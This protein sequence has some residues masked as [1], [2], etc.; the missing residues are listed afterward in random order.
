MHSRAPRR[1]NLATATGVIAVMG[2]CSLV[3]VAATP[4]AAATASPPT[5]TVPGAAASTT[6]QRVTLASGLTAP[7]PAPGSGT[8]APIGIT[9]TRFIGTP[10]ATEPRPQTNGSS[11]VVFAAT[12]TGT[13]GGGPI[14]PSLAEIGLTSSYSLELPPY[15]VYQATTP[16]TASGAL[17]SSCACYRCGDFFSAEADP[18]NLNAVWVTGMYAAGPAWGT[19][20]AQV[21]A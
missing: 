12:G 7:S 13:S 4:T 21:A 5:V 19:Q 1:W 15:Y 2:S 6:P 17:D 8:Q 11:V 3:G 9:S 16:Y 14:Y 20:I 18:V 10:S